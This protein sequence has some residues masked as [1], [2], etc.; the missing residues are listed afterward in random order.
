MD[1]YDN[2]DVARPAVETQKKYGKVEGH[3]RSKVTKLFDW[4]TA[5][6]L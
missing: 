1:H 2:R 5:A 6:I 4:P 3:V